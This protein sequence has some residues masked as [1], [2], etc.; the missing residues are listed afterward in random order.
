MNDKTTKLSALI[1]A[2][3]SSFLTPFMISSVN[4]ALPAVGREFKTDA[5]LLSW[6]ATSYLLAASVALVPFGKLADIYG[7]KKIFQIGQI[8]VTATSLLAAISA[9]ASM[10]IV[11]RVFQGIGGA[12]GCGRGIFTVG[13]SGFYQ[14]R[15]SSRWRNARKLPRLSR[16]LVMTQGQDGCTIFL[17]EETRQFP[18]V[19]GSAVDTTGAGDVFA[20]AFLVRLFQTGGNPSEAAQFANKVASLS[21]TTSGLKAKMVAISSQLAV[22]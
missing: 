22:S 4:I 8:I 2:S 7:R 9:S 19:P 3:V 20:A 17:G 1:I 12:M 18:S 21:I 16:L 5:V 13:S 11:F 10:L 14:R 6:V 15:R